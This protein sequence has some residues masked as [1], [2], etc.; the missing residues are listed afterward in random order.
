MCVP[1]QFTRGVR[2]GQRTK[3]MCEPHTIAIALHIH[4]FS[5]GGD[6]LGKESGDGG[7]D[8]TIDNYYNGG[9]DQH[10]TNRSASA[11][12]LR[13]LTRFNP[14]E[15]WQELTAS[16]VGTRSLTR[17]A[18]LAVDG[19]LLITHLR[20]NSQIIALVFAFICNGQRCFP[21]EFLPTHY[22]NRCNTTSNLGWTET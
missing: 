11:K 3:L 21:Q 16:L 18:D 15:A 7:W 9:Q 12:N 13:N 19:I 22:H 10:K 14:C 8:K 2:H 17:P 4:G 5:P 1:T 6:R 20:Y